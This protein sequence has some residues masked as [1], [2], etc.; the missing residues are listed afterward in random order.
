MSSVTTKEPRSTRGLMTQLSELPV[1]ALPALTRLVGT[2]L[3]G[4]KGRSERGV[5]GE[6]GEH[7]RACGEFAAERPMIAR[8][9]AEG[10]PATP[11][12]PDK[13]GHRHRDQF[14]KT[15]TIF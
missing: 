7:M 2:A 14:L 3:C 10:G 4:D 1:P 8:L 5:T 12:W 6:C 15:A 11:T 9:A 13:P